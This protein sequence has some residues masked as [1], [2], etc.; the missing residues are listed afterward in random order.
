MRKY[1]YH[2]EV[3]TLI[4]QFIDAFDEVV[5][6]RYN[7]DQEVQDQIQ[8][9]YVY[10]PKTRT[11]HDLINKQGH[12]TLPVVSVWITGVSRDPNRVFNKIEGPYIDLQA[13]TSS[14][15][16]KPWQPVPVDIKVGMS[17]I[18]KYQQD[19]DQILTN[20]IPYCDPYIVVSWKF[21]NL[22]H[23]IRSHIIWDE[24][25]SL[26]YPMD[27]S[28]TQP[29]RIT[30]DTSF[31]IKGWMFKDPNEPVGK[32]YKI[33]TTFTG[34]SDLYCRYEAMKV[35]EDIPFSTDQFVLSAR[36]QLFKVVPYVTYAGIS[37][38]E[39]AV[40]GSMFNEVCGL[41]VHGS[42]GIYN[43]ETIVDI[44]SAYPKLSASYP[45]FTG[46]A[47]ND[48]TIDTDNVITFTLPTPQTSGFIDIIPYNEAGYGKLTV[49]VVR[50]TYNPYSEDMPEYYTYVE[51]QEP[52]VSGIQVH[53][54]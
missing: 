21:P 32:I 16:S 33:T 42:S 7:E 18:T 36:P 34:V 25:V 12:I 26:Q 14:N 5:V 31:T 10:A 48:Y 3:R 53:I 1:T 23:E 8:V 11:L 51:W 54:L 50:P 24:N 46:V 37:G 49:D 39:F 47:V 6:R 13:N 38:T 40:I 43:N 35:M 27:I 17:I 4:A 15:F 22:N 29:Y 30:A 20:F 41:Y 52:C 45:A 2:R 28:K 9:R 19:L 44:F